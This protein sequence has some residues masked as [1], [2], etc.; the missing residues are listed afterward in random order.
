MKNCCMKIWQLIRPNDINESSVK[1]QHYFCWQFTRFEFELLEKV[2]II[3]PSS[4]FSNKNREKTSQKEV[5]SNILKVFMPL[6]ENTEDWFSTIK[7][8]LWQRLA[9]KD[10]L[11]VWQQTFLGQEP[12]RKHIRVPWHD[13]RRPLSLH[14]SQ[15]TKQ[16]TSQPASN[17]DWY[18][19]SCSN[20]IITFYT[21][22]E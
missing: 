12:E 9:G 11:N 15:E 14:S 19:N 7:S 1:S 13:S 18:T 17:E 20:F 4:S 6:M 21:K 10:C 22:R 3:R 2:W 5:I 16:F 8:T